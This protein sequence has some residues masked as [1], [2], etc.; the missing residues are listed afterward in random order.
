MDLAVDGA[1]VVDPVRVL[2]GMVRVEV[3]EGVTEA[4]VRAGVVVVGTG[5]RAPWVPGSASSRS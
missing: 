1:R 4:G 3:S 2:A 5:P